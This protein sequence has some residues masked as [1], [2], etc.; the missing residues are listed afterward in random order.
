MIYTFG[1]KSNKRFKL[2]LKFYGHLKTI[3]IIILFFIIN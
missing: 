3:I 2:D 1:L